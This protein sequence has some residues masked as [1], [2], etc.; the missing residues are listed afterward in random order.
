MIYSF[1][2]NDEQIPG[3]YYRLSKQKFT[4]FMGTN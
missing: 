3:S 4:A 1:L 2:K